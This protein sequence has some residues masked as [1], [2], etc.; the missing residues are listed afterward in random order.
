MLKDK[1][2]LRSLSW[3]LFVFAI[4]YLIIS[5][6]MMRRD[7]Q[8]SWVLEG[9][10]IPFILFLLTFCLVFFTEK[11]IT[12]ILCIAVASRIIFSLVPALKYMWFPGGYIDQQQ[13]FNLASTV[14]WT[15][16]IASSSDISFQYYI[17][18]PLEHI[19]F[20]A[21]SIFPNIQLATVL[22]FLPVLLG[23]LYPLLTYAIVRNIGLARNNTYTKFVIFVSSVPLALYSYF[24]TGTLLGMLLSLI[25]LYLLV[26]IITKKDRR[27]WMLCIFF[28]LG[29]AIAHT[30]SSVFLAVFLV[31]IAALQKMPVLQRIR[32][33]KSKGVL[34]P[35]A[36]SIAIIGLTWLMYN[37]SATLNQM[38]IYFFSVFYGGS[39]PKAEA[40][41]SVLF[42]LAS[43]DPLAAFTTVM[44]YYGAE[45]F[46]LLLAAS[47]IFVIIFKKQKLTGVD[48]FL[49]IFF[50]LSI[51]G[52]LIGLALGL[53]AARF[54]TFANIL[55]PFFVGYALYY[56]SKKL[57]WVLPLLV[58]GLLFFST[59]E[60]YCAE[61]LIPQ[62]NILYP[63]LPDDVPIANVFTYNSIYQRTL[64][65]FLTSY[66]SY[67]IIASDL[68][69]RN[70]IVGLANES[71]VRE[72]MP[73][74]YY[75]LGGE[76]LQSY[77]I[78]V[79]HLPGKAGVFAE[80]AQ[81]RSP[82]EIAKTVQGD[83]V[84]YNNG[85]SYVLFNQP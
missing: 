27:Y 54:L 37:A 23:A 22:Q 50:G 59:I 40:V 56:F 42:S 53:G 8:D 30:I 35:A 11:K 46:A 66:A 61:P 67:G 52:S 25:I 71:Y 55:A 18:A 44:V 80:P 83:S 65:G 16:H 10:E 20:S 7:Y 2:T 51:F 9:I 43:A 84:V 17:S 15:G 1:I 68:V 31:V 28:V 72:H 21:T 73:V 3:I 4:A 26:S 79:T 12:H 24:V 39:G 77:N 48:H 47:G 64:T 75:P 5:A 19:L 49:L 76:P 45:L 33:I 85:E 74:Y 29:L 78:F 58:V 81:F 70:Q 60:V 41:P 34:L 69:T 14:I 13:Q 62:A 6:L 63:E 57:R 32:L 38:S 36:L 82:S